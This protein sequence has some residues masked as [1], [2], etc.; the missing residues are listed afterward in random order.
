[1]NYRQ[2]YARKA[3]CEKRIKEVCPQCPN[4]P[5]IYAFYR[6]DPDTHIRFAYIGQARSLISRI[7]QHLQ[8]YDHL[9]LSL[10]K[11]GI[12]N[13]E[14]NPHGWMIRYIECSLED[15][16]K[17][18]TEFIKQWADAGFQLLNKTGGSQSDG[19]VV[20]DNKKPS[21]GY[22]DGVDQGEKN[23]R[24]FIADLFAKHLTVS[25]KRTPPTVNQQKAL[26]KFKK[27]CDWEAEENA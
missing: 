25:T 24:R 10:K 12:Y 13:K 7:A 23:A 21:R 2:I 4:R 19:K 17:K 3:E 22:F 6:T 5:G 8:E 16:D 15:L 9:A 26:E 11:R 20:F 14:K 1:M 18:E 27:F